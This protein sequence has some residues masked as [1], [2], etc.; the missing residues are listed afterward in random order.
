MRAVLSID[1]AA[2]DYGAGVA[3]RVITGE[4]VAAASELR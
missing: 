4:A 2:A 3:R 1:S